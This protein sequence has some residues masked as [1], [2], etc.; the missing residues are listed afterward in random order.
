MGKSGIQRKP[1]ILL[2]LLY[3]FGWGGGR[4]LVVMYSTWLEMEWVLY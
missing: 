4:Y 2:C 3:N 1:D